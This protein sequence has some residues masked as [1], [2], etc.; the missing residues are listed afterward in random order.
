MWLQGSVVSVCNTRPYNLLRFTVTSSSAVDRRETALQG[1]SV[2]AEIEVEVLSLR[3]L[4]STEL[5]VLVIVQMPVI[6]AHA[7]VFSCNL[8]KYRHKLLYI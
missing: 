4:L 6:N 3:R 1:E 5:D 2:L 7:L 8:Y